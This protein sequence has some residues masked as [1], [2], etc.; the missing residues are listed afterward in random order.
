MSE[1]TVY[2]NGAFVPLAAAQVSVLDRGFLF[3]DGVY[4]VIPVY[5]GRLFRLEQHL[6]RLAQ[7]LAAIRLANPLD[8]AQWHTMLS[9]LVAR[10]GGGDQSLY[11]QVTRGV[12]RR[13][14]AFP[15]E[16]QPTLFAMSTPVPTTHE[17]EPGIAA[18]TVED[19]RWQRCNIKAI[20]LLPSVLLRQ[21]ALDQGA[22]EAI[23][24]RDGLLTEGAACNVFIVRSGSVITPPH[25]PHLLPGITRD[26][27]VEL[28]HTHAIPCEERDVGEAEL[29][30]ADELW[31]T[32]SPKGVVPVVRLDGAPVG[33]GRP[34]PLWQRLALLYRDYQHQFRQGQLS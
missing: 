32:S 12:A 26:L 7:S 23:M 4:E 5:A 8:T 20:T 3:G 16:V 13:D 2:L 18:I 25:S 29:R 34:G 22:Q 17:D 19:I 33:K 6:Q 10:N 24:V 21:Q 30:S 31:I 9:E 11:L 27:V 15:A 14:L 1:A 28:C